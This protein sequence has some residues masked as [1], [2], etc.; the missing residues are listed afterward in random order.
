MKSAFMCVCVL[1]LNQS[2]V[3]KLIYA[4]AFAIII[5][6]ISLL[7]TKHKE[8]DTAES[9][10]WQKVINTCTASQLKFFSQTA[11][12]AAALSVREIFH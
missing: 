7:S 4:A 2:E 12:A 9:D 10:I 11:A 3:V 5:I 6:I 8:F 1:A